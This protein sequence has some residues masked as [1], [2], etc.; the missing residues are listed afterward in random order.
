MGALAHDGVAEPAQ[1]GADDRE[2]AGLDRPHA[3]VGGDARHRVDLLTEGGHPEVV[4]DVL[5]LDVEGTALPLG[6]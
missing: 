3:D 4:Q 5:G 6:R 2:R 1:L